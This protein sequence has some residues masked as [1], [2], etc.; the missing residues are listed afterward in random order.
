MYP[1]TA[2]LELEE[3]R[4]AWI[5][6]PA[7]S[8]AVVQ[9][10]PARTFLLGLWGRMPSTLQASPVSLCAPLYPCLQEDLKIVTERCTQKLSYV[11]TCR[12]NTVKPECLPSRGWSVLRGLLGLV[13]A[14]CFPYTGEMHPGNQRPPLASPHRPQGTRTWR[15]TKFVSLFY[16]NL[17]YS[18][19]KGHF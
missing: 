4:K 14:A 11:G 13:H 7:V 17:T 9:V 10:T 3:G 1:E 15:H 12:I 8:P 2:N 5:L 18:V 16:T 19:V 6:C